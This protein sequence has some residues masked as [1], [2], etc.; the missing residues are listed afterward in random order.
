MGA[1]CCAGRFGSW[2]MLGLVSVSPRAREAVK[3][4][5]CSGVM[6]VS[7]WPMAM[8]AVSPG[9]HRS[10]MLAS[11]HAGSATWG[12][13]YSKGSSMPVGWL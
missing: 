8:L 2:R 5:T 13:A 7:P 3:Q 10:F 4:A 1:V 6:S 9:T 12:V 11:F